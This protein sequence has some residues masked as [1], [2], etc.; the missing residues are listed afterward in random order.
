MPDND[1]IDRPR[2]D[3]DG[4]PSLVREELERQ[5]RAR[6]GAGDTPTAD[7]ETTP[8]VPAAWQAPPSPKMV[9]LHR[10]PAGRDAELEPA[11]AVLQRL[12]RKSDPKP[13]SPLEP[14]R[15]NASFLNR[16]NA[17]ER[18]IFFVFKDCTYHAFACHHLED[19]RLEKSAKPGG[20]AD[21]LMRF[22]GT[23]PHDVRLVGGPLRFIGDCIA[24]GIMPWVWELPDGQKPAEGATVITAIIITKVDRK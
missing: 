2:P 19:I 1:V 3:Y 12:A 7:G 18:F 8:P 24:L 6:L 15:A 4:Y 21:L 10:P 5:D 17:L 16:L 23:E 9:P 13:E 14:Y 20:G 11:E 22:A